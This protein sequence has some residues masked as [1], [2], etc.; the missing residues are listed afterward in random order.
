MADEKQG[1]EKKENSL[2]D[3]AEAAAKR[4]EEANA[5][6]DE[7]LRKN[8]EIYARMKLGGETGGRVEIPVKVETP[9]EYRERIM[10]GG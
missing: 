5:R 3:R 8:E 9:T 7:L 1:V 10:R 6:A 2:V 4:I